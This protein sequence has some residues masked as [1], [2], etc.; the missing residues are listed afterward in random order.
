M[1][2]EREAYKL[3]L[4]W[5]LRLTVVTLPVLYNK[6]IPPCGGKAG[7]SLSLNLKPQTG[8]RPHS[9]AHCCHLRICWQA[10]FFMAA[11]GS[12]GL[13]SM[14]SNTKVRWF[15]PTWLFAHSGLKSS[16]IATWSPDGA[17]AASPQHQLG[18][19]PHPCPCTGLHIILQWKQKLMS[20]LGIAPHSPST[21]KSSELQPV[22]PHPFQEDDWLPGMALLITFAWQKCSRKTKARYPTLPYASQSYRE[23]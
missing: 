18:D 5:L 8:L 6:S 16:P 3:D 22:P 12:F 23:M 4:C 7:S 10:A 17:G 19:H 9:A 21:P 11:S 2:T 14:S 13:K 20:I 1:N 15:L